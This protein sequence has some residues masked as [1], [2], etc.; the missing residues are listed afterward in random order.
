M[1]EE[2]KQSIVPINS[3][4]YIVRLGCTGLYILL[5]WYHTVDV[6]SKIRCYFIFT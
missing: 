2:N 4:M 1:G 5:V 6:V 3:S